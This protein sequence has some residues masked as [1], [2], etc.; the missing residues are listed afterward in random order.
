M[1]DITAYCEKCDSE[2]EVESIYIGK[3]GYFNIRLKCKHS[4]LYQFPMKK[5]EA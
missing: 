2:I 1:K 3:E 4:I 5:E